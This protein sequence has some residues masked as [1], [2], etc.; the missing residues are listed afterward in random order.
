[1]SFGSGYRGECGGSDEG[2]QENCGSEEGEAGV[3]MVNDMGE[4][5]CGA[6]VKSLHG[7]LEEV[8][9]KR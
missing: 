6:V 4:H 9:S 7:E 3:C 5:V 8:F 2:L 1:M